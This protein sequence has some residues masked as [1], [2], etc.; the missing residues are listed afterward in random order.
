M[1]RIDCVGGACP[2][3]NEGPL[4]VRWS[5]LERIIARILT[6]TLDD[7]SCRE[8]QCQVGAERRIGPAVLLAGSESVVRRFRHQ[9]H[10]VTGGWQRVK[11]MAARTRE[12]RFRDR[13]RI[14]IVARGQ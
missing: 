5:L 3:G 13:V 6:V 9:C 11:T 14:Q 10:V 1:I 2:S 4:D 7:V 12:P 8:C